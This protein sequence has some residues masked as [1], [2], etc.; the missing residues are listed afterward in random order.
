MVCRYILVRDN[1]HTDVPPD[2]VMFF[3]NFAVAVTC[4]AFCWLLAI[5]AFKGWVTSRAS[6]ASAFTRHLLFDNHVA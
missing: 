2:D 3:F 6:R 4:L 5:I 1:S